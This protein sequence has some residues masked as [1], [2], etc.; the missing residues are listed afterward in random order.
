MI[1]LSSDTARYASINRRKRI[2]SDPSAI[3]PN[4]GAASLERNST[5]GQRRGSGVAN[6][7][8]TRLVNAFWV[9]QLSS[10]FLASRQ[11]NRK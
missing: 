8:F 1:S 7:G 3:G 6:E 10:L 11:G 9:K 4:L 2:K 5:K